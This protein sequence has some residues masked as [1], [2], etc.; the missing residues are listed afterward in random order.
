MRQWG[1]N[2]ALIDHVAWAEF[3]AVLPNPVQKAWRTNG[4]R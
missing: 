3:A 2:L 1:E 4:W